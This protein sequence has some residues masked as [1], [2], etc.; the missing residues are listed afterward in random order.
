VYRDTQF[1]ITGA[2]VSPRLL[3]R[4]VHHPAHPLNDYFARFPSPSPCSLTFPTVPAR[5]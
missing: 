3:C 1:P 5:A 2:V 4:H